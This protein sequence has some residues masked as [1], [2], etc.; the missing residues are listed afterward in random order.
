MATS[1]SLNTARTMISERIADLEARMPR[2]APDAIAKKM[3][4]IRSIAAAQGMTALEGL[5]DYAA[6]HATMPGHIQA[7]RAA[8]DHMD[9]ALGSERPCDRE[10]I[11]AAIAVRLH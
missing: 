5:A 11:L 2:L 10:T 9:E 6:H 3:N 1:D 4:A 7:T 8:I